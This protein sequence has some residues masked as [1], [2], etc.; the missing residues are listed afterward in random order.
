[1]TRFCVKEIKLSREIFLKIFIIF[2]GMVSGQ[3]PD[4]EAVGEVLEGC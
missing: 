1:M 2:G 3:L 4:A